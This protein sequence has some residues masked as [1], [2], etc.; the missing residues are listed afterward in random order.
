[1]QRFRG[2][3][4]FGE[5]RIAEAEKSFATEIDDLRAHYPDSLP[6]S[7]TLLLRAAA[8]TALGRY[9]TSREHSTK[10][11]A[12]GSRSAP[13]PRSPPRTTAT[14]WSS[15]GCCWPRAMP[16]APRPACKQWRRR[17][18]KRRFAWTKHTA[19]LALAQARLLQ[20]RADEARQ[21]AQQALDHVQASP[22]RERY[23][24]LEAEA[25]LR[26]GQAR[27][28]RRRPTFGPQ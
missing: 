10:R 4:L 21:F 14:G 9:E 12:C 22:L 15:P 16:A 2:I 3:A 28:H 23:P 18:K 13:V 5:G 17:K 26:L 25:W 8:L 1:M 6:L 27:R 24:R 7:R 20:G 19:R 11:G